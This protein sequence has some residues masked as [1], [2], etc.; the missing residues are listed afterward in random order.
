V[1]LFLFVMVIPGCQLDYIWNELQSRI[2]GHTCDPDLEAERHKFLTW[3]L[4]W[5]SWG[6]VAMKSLGPGKVVQAFNPRRLRQGDVWGQ[7][8]PG[9]KQIPDPGLR[10][11]TFNLGHTFCW[12]PTRD[13]GR[14][15]ICSSLSA[16]IYLPAHLL[17]PS[18][19]SSHRRPAETTSLMGLSNY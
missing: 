9:T 14:R 1:I 18:S 10:A 5:R 6:I 4:A 7:G 12:R 11:N 16:C 2:G 8:Q 17:T 3:I 15:K 13:I 19:I